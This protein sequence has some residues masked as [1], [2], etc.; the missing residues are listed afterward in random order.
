MI[1]EELKLLQALCFCSTPEKCEITPNHWIWQFLRSV[2]DIEMQNNFANPDVLEE[3]FN[4]VVV[5]FRS[6]VFDSELTL[7]E[8]TNALKCALLFILSK[9]CLDIVTSSS[10]KVVTFFLEFNDNLS[11]D[12]EISDLHVQ[13]VC[14]SSRILKLIQHVML[15]CFPGSW[16]ESDNPDLICI[17]LR[18]I[19]LKI[20]SNILQ[21]ASGLKLKNCASVYRNL[22]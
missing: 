15:K 18:V 9:R 14:L 10:L 12:Q 11:T 13:A 20:R 3:A 19:L 1:Q 17:S 5:G 21:K 22:G 2:F 16:L 6:L 8:G 4:F 7:L